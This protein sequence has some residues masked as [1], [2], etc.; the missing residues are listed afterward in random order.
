MSTFQQR[1][2]PASMPKTELRRSEL[3][4]VRQIPD[5]V[6]SRPVSDVA[7]EPPSINPAASKALLLP[8]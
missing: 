5:S 3:F 6:E 8:G 7:A 2:S 4:R 1:R